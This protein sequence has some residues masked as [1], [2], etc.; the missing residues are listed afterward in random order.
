MQ[1]TDSSVKR[2]TIYKGWSGLMEQNDQ[3]TWSVT[4]IDIEVT[5]LDTDVLVT[6]FVYSS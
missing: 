3:I 1:P 6:A 2:P 5:D 4:K